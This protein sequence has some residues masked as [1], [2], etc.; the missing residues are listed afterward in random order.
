MAVLY[1]CDL[2][3]HVETCAY[4]GSIGRVAAAAWALLFVLKL[5]ALAW[6]LELRP[7]RSAIVVPSVGA[8]GLAVLPQLFREVD[9]AARTTLVMLWAFGVGAAGLW[10]SLRVDSAVGFDV[11]GRRALRG[12]WVMWAVLAFGHVLYWSHAQRVQLGALVVVAALLATRFLRRELDVWALSLTTLIVVGLVTPALLSPSALM[13]AVVLTLRACRSPIERRDAPAVP[14][15]PYRGAVFAE[16]P[17]P[18]PTVF[19]LAP[20]RALT[21]L[22]VGAI[23][24]AYLAI[25]TREW[26]GGVWPAHQLAL[27]VVLVLACAAVMVKSRRMIALAPVTLAAT[28]LATQLGWLAAPRGALQWGV[29]TIA[30]GFGLLALTLAVSW[31]LRPREASPPTLGPPDRALAKR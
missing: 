6:A 4:L 23:S 13:V 3:L 26:S 30:L 20:P 16:P 7:S 28:H 27:D 8:I 17:E 31:R 12:A 18:P 21:R 9:P 29:T 11:R 5:L 19:G 15:E 14:E 10:S 24:A 22:V 2:T 1:Q 25:W